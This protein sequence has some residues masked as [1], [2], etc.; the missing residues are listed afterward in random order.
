MTDLEMMSRRRVIQRRLRE[1]GWTGRN[2]W[3]REEAAAL[4]MELDELTW[5]LI[6]GGWSAGMMNDA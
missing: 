2:I 6:H 3:H 5:A 4:Q 1:M